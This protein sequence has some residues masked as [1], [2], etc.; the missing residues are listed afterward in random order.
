[1]PP[2]SSVFTASV[3]TIMMAMMA[4][5]FLIATPVAGQALDQR[6]IGLLAYY[7]DDDWSMMP[8]YTFSGRCNVSSPAGTRDWL[9]ID[10][11]GCYTVTDD[12]ELSMD[13]KRTGGMAKRCD[14]CVRCIDLDKDTCIRCVCSQSDGVKHWA[15][16]D[17]DDDLWVDIP[18]SRICCGE[19]WG[20]PYCGF[21]GK[22]DPPGV[23]GQAAYTP[24]LP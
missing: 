1:M 5:L 3:A 6:G 8:G 14:R 11:T 24:T 10:I 19:W 4:M 2:S 18:N 17:L 16:K 23:P 13:N 7:C 22:P 12:G 21:R 15:V 9:S 20:G